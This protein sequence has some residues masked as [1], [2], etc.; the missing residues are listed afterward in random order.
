MKFE[1]WFKCGS[2]RR[3]MGEFLLESEA[4]KYVDIIH[5]GHWNLFELIPKEGN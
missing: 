3:K 4:R 1:I 2:I 5:N